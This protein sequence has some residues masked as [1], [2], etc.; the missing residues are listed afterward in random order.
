MKQGDEITTG[1]VAARTRSLSLIST[2]M[3]RD[4]SDQPRHDPAR[5]SASATALPNTKRNVPWSR[6]SLRGPWPKMSAGS[7]AESL[8]FANPRL[9]GY[10]DTCESAVGTVV[11]D[12]SFDRL[13]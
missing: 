1:R 12:D 8:A 13:G 3:A 10:R 2:L 7:A 4:I 11:A 5:L 6:S 9:R